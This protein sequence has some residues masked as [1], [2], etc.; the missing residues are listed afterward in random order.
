MSTVDL[1]ITND[2][3]MTGSELTGV[4]VDQ[5]GGPREGNVNVD[6][7]RQ[8]PP[9]SPAGNQL[10]R[11]EPSQGKKRAP[12]NSRK[13]NEV[14]KK[15]CNNNRDK[16][17]DVESEEDTPQRNSED[18]PKEDRP[19]LFQDDRKFDKLSYVMAA[20]ICWEFRQLKEKKAMKVRETI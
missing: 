18:F 12:E 16:E 6:R 19:D 11:K 17:T 14:R 7:E 20:K 5:L 3:S 10:I 1:D 4:I 8:D 13:T 2:V 9:L 15:R